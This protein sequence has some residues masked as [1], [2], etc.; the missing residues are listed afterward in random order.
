[1]S[2]TNIIGVK[3]VTIFTI[4]YTHNDIEEINKKKSNLI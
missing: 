4:E 2:F 3:L 1:M